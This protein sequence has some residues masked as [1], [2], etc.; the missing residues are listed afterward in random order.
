MSESEQSRR[1]R[2]ALSRDDAERV[3]ASAGWLAATPAPFRAEVL[4][5]APGTWVWSTDGPM[6]PLP[7]LHPKRP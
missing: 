5:H 4:R 2:P 3:V 1:R 6:P 7:A